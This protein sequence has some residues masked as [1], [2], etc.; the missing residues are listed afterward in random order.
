MQ[1]E[2]GRST[3]ESVAAL[4]LVDGLSPGCQRTGKARRRSSRALGSANT[5]LANQTLAELRDVSSLEAASIAYADIQSPSRVDSFTTANTDVKGR[6]RLVEASERLMRLRVVATFLPLLMAAR[7][8][9][10]EDVDG[11]V[12]LVDECEKYAFRV[13][14]VLESRSD[15]GHSQMCRLG[16]T[17]LTA[18]F[19]SRM[20]SS[21]S[22]N[23]ARILPELTVPREDPTGT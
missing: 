4:A 9:H 15:R 8:R 7:V 10:P 13:Y 18:T 21:T 3:D 20:P 6:R 1:A 16:T 2:L 17:Y 14:R 5:A 23:H 22:S 19:R 11:Y 12:A